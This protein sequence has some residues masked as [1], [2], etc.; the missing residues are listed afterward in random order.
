MRAPK[1]NQQTAKTSTT[2]NKALVC[3]TP[4]ASLVGTVWSSVSRS[5]KPKGAKVVFCR[6][7]KARMSSTK[8][9]VLMPVFFVSASEMAARPSVAASWLAGAR[10]RSM[11]A[12][13]PKRTDWPGRMLEKMGN[14]AKVSGAVLMPSMPTDQVPSWVLSVPAEVSRHQADKESATSDNNTPRAAKAC[15]S[16]WIKISGSRRPEAN[17]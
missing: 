3:I 6:S 5:S 16:G 7:M 12:T 1:N 13:S 9:R 4:M 8:F 15:G 10:W 17:T 11:R 14:W 2:P